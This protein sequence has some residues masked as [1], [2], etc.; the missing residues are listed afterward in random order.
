MGL[1]QSENSISGENHPWWAGG[2]KA[3]CCKQ[4]GKKFKIRQDGVLANG[5]CCSYKC[6]GLDRSKNLSGKN[7]SGWQ[8]GGK[9]VCCKY[10]A[11]EFRIENYRILDSGN[12]CSYECVHLYRS[13]NL[14]GE[15][16]PSWKNG[17]GE[18]VYCKQCGIE[19]KIKRCQINNSR[20]SR[21]N[22]C[23]H[24]CHGLYISENIIG[25]KASGWKGGKSF[26][27]YPATFN[28]PFKRKIRERDGHVCAICK[29]W[30]NS[31]HHINYVK[32]DTVPEN[33]I[34]LCGSCHGT[35]GINRN[36][37]QATLTKLMSARQL[38]NG[39]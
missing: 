7:H 30:G 3:V 22:F 21:G 31:V 20:N 2:K 38:Y 36:Y 6:A 14:R 27:P 23:S 19:F 12:F 39:I 11:I 17:G 35:T 9:V 37:W 28:A 8:G 33:C 1:Y 5:N 26:E 4:C 15:N 25:E 29:L 16:H 13:K 24:K 32:M 10:C 18:T 34:I